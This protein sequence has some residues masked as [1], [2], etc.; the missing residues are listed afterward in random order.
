MN[1][2][3]KLGQFGLTEEEIKKIISIFS[4]YPAVKS[5]IIFGSRAKGNYRQYS[6]ID[7]ALTGT[8]L[9]LTTQ[10]LIESEIDDLLLPYKFD[11]AILEKIKNLNLIN[12]IERVG[13]LLYSRP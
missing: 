9:S 13:K 5:A 2:E 6:D 8:D 11:F 12:H 10:Q 4:K 3:I 1:I 7:I